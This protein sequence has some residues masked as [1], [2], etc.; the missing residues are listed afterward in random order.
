MLVVAVQAVFG[1]NKYPD[2]QAKHKF[3][4]FEPEIM[5]ADK[6]ADKPAE[7]AQLAQFVLAVEHVPN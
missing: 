6:L 2:E 5:E 7:A 4:A 3:E 1:D